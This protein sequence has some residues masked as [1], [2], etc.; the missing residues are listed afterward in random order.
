MII[1]NIKFTQGKEGANPSEITATLTV[2]EAL[3]IAKRAGNTRGSG[4]NN[5]I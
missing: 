5:S 2:E 1:E 3:W 4:A